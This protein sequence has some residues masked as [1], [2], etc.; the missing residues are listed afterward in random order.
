MHIIEICI[1][2]S[3]FVK[4][5]NQVIE[6]LR[7]L[8]SEMNLEDKVNLQGSFCMGR[9]TSGLGIRVDGVI[10]EG[11]TLHNASTILRSKLEEFI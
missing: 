10:L 8:L 5:S 6:L 9:C 3:C 11:I 4:G 2:S 7:T 1:G